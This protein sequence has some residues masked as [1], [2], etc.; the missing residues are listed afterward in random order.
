MHLELNNLVLLGCATIIG[1]YAGL[2]TK[3]FRLPS[4]IGYMLLGVFLGSSALNIITEQALDRLAVISEITLAFIAFS[5]GSELSIATLR[6]LGS[7]IVPIILA[8][9]LLAFLAVTALILAVTRDLPLALVL[10]AMAPAS[11]PAGTV[12]VIQETKSRGSLT[13]ALYAVVGFDDGLAIVI[14]GFAAAMAKHLLAGEADG[15]VEINLLS[16]LMYPFIDILF[17][18]LVGGILGLLFSLLMRLLKREED[19]LI[20]VFGFVMLSTGIAL[21]LNLSLIL[22]NM[23]V[24]FMFVNTRRADLVKRVLR[25]THGATPFL[26]ILFFCL[27]GAHMKFSAL[28]ALGLIGVVYI[29]GRSAGLIFGARLGATIGG[30]EGKIKKYLGIGIL[31]QAGVAIGLSL[32]VRNELT[33][34]GTPHAIRIG[35][36]VLTMTT[37]TSIFFELIGPVLTKIALGKAG[38]I[39]ESRDTGSDKK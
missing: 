21:S 19:S 26:F 7:G 10:G 20:L 14:F 18:L 11:D 23:V 39:P 31:S 35:A 30:I 24:G 28:P 15:A 32:I 5:I 29:I 4:L 13:K 25:R 9:S 6:K 22:T 3:R 17:S 33:A 12:Y 2:F 38:E 34:I 27:A 8:E 1:Y 16:S 36:V 37:A